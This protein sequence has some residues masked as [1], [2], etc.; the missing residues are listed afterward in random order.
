MNNS[1]KQEEI[2]RFLSG[3]IA[4]DNYV[5]FWGSCFSNFF[6]T[7]FYLDGRYWSTS[8]KYFMYQKAMT[9]YDTKIAEEILK[10]EEPREIK[11][12]GREVKNFNESVWNNVREEIMYRGVKAKFEQDTISKQCLLMPEYKD[13]HFVEGSPIDKIWGVGIRYDNSKIDNKENWDGL[14]LLGKILDR[15][16]EEIN[17]EEKENL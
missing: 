2:E 12:L 9:F 7:R 14:N 3:S 16:R 15:V 11:K 10:L 17:S 8:E 6:P 13:K 4:Y 1:K 5:A